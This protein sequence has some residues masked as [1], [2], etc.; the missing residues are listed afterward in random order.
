[1][2]VKYER[3]RFFNADRGGIYTECKM[4]SWVIVA[5]IN[6]RLLLFSAKMHIKC[7]GILV[8]LSRLHRCRYDIISISHKE[9]EP[10]VCRDT[11]STE[12]KVAIIDKAPWH[13]GARDR[14]FWESPESVVYIYRL[15]GTMRTNGGGGTARTVSL[16]LVV[17]GGILHLCA[18]VSVSVYHE[19][20]IRHLEV[21]VYP[22]LDRFM[23]TFLSMMLYVYVNVY[24]FPIFHRSV[25]T[26]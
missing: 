21:R 2:L 19:L 1:M 10:A 5:N 13:E 8:R 26:V 20:R 3:H 25:N 16:G 15:P 7:T 12:K 4:F 11:F 18:F 14:D 24:M 22:L 23:C 17:C 6:V 9:L